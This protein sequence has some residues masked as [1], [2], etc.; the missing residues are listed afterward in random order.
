MRKIVVP[1]DGRV[2]VGVVRDAISGMAEA[3]YI[4]VEMASAADLKPL[5]AMT[6]NIVTDGAAELKGKKRK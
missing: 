4:P 2:S 1:A 3:D 5:P 6:Y